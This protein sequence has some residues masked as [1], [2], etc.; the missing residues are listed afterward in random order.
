M[1]T[2]KQV[3]VFAEDWGRL[4]S[5][6]Q[7]IIRALLGLGWKVI[8]INSIGMRQPSFSW[9]YFRRL[10]GKIKGFFK[11]SQTSQ[12][13][14]PGLTVIHPMTIPLYGHKAIDAINRW[15]LQRQLRTPMKNQEFI[16]PLVWIALPTA[17]P[18]LSL[19]KDSRIVYYC[20]DD[21]SVFDGI[22]QKLILALENKLIKKADIN[23][24]TNPALAEKMPPDRW[25]FMDH[26][27]DLAAFQKPFPRPKDLPQGKPIAGFYGCLSSW[28]DVPL[29]EKCVRA[30]P[31]INFVLIGPCEIDISALLAHKNVWYLGFKAYK[32]I[33][34]YSQH[35]DLSLLPFIEQQRTFAANPLTL[36]EY[37]ASGKP[38]V[39]TNLPILQAFKN[40]V[41]LADT[42]DDFVQ[43]I[44]LAMQDHKAEARKL[45][46]A[47]YSWD[48]LVKG[49]VAKLNLG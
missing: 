47:N 16:K 30:L 11:T 27:V 35:W 6:T 29:L 5:S 14:P 22:N 4:P 12:S 21:F 46:I 28:I 33:P 18:Y 2:A 31:Q 13:L 7:H 23:I 39:S 43:A 20:C 37:L 19:F 42:P 25:V 44:P 48:T 34:A 17:Y 38:V 36:K 49:L 15:V 8:W 10:A 45:F 41:Y 3:V 24:V 9:L 40:V 1:K 26:G 32:D